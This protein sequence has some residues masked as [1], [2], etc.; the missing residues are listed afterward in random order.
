MLNHILPLLE[1]LVAHDTRN[2]PRQ[3]AAD[4]IFATL[5]A[6]LPGF[7]HSVTDYGAGAITLLSVRGAPKRVYNF[8]LD[9]VP[10]AAGWSTDPHALVVKDGRAFGLGACD[11]KGAAAAMAVAANATSGDLALLFSSDEEANDPRCIRGFLATSHGFTEA[12]VAEPTLAQ[13]RIMHRGIVSARVQFAGI[14]G[15][16]SERRAL[17]D[18]AVHRAVGWANAALTFARS[19][20]AERFEELEGLP[21]NL[22]RIDG[23]IKGNVIADACEI[24]FGFRPL[25][26][27]SVDELL[28][29]F[30]GMAPPAELAA[31][32]ELFRGPPLPAGRGEAA[33]AQLAQ[34]RALAARLGLPLG[35]AVNFWTEASLFS[36][37]GLAALVFGPG[38][39]AQAHTAD[40]WVALDQ[41][42]TVARHYQRIIESAA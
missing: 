41:L 29:L 19:R 21:F 4:G 6:A 30:R 14:A 10:A 18:S 32:E 9:T 5:I 8:H 16:A 20:Q 36:E 37:A 28:A 12:V 35:P 26:S 25:P 24:R 34:G 38:D 15:H 23:G 22:G 31:F 7:T 2:P 17:A 11:I 27:Q 42:E 33:A 40:E 1:R 39:I 13:A 3:I